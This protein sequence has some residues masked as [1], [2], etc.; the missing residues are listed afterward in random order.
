MPRFH[1]YYWRHPGF[2]RR[3]HEGTS[4]VPRRYLKGTTKENE[5][6]VALRVHDRQAGTSNLSYTSWPFECATTCLDLTSIGQVMGTRRWTSRGNLSFFSGACLND[7]LHLQTFWWPCDDHILPH[8]W[9]NTTS[10]VELETS[11]CA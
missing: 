9:P 4:K 5:E 7:A 3:Y 11:R 8:T 10:E 2:Q 1:E 6:R